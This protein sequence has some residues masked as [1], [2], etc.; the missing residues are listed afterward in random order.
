MRGLRMI[1]GGTKMTSDEIVDAV[2]S[3]IRDENAKYAVL[4]DGAW[5]SEV[6]KLI[7]MKI[8]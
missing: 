6:E 3:Y 7:Y 1:I 2:I 5:G 8:I 4:I